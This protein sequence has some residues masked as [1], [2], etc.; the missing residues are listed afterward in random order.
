MNKSLAT[1]MSLAA[2]VF[3]LV[4]FLMG[5]VVNELDTKNTTYHYQLDE[6]Q[7]KFK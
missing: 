5:V 4:Y 7:I 3:F 6:Y 2:V 1:F